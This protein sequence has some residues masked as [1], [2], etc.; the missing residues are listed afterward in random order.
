[1]AD[2]SREWSPS[3]SKSGGGS[4]MSAAL[5]RPIAGVPAWGW[6]F[7][8]SAGFIA[9]MIWR[10]RKQTAAAQA[11][12]ANDPNAPNNSL[13]F[14]PNA[15]DPSTGLLYSQ[16]MP[17]GYGLPAGPLGQF[18]SN[19]PGNPSY[20]V[21]LTEQGLPGPITN[22]QW[23]RLVADSL[24]SKGSDPT[25]VENALSK[26]LSGQPL[27][28]AETA[29][30]NMGLQ[31]FGSPPEGVI[32]ATPAPATAQPFP[33]VYTPKKGDTWESIARLAFPGAT[34]EQQASAANAIAQMNGNGFAGQ[35]VPG[36]A[37]KIGTQQDWV[38]AGFKT[39]GGSNPIVSYIGHELTV[40][41][42]TGQPS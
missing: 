13:T 2:E 34:P 27:T 38:N 26:F 4:G 17:A 11:A 40:P 23:S 9:F 20:P 41:W 3:S 22:L 7:V 33:W 1:M 19:D 39:T 36:Y 15:V 35:P 6:A 12:A 32:P 37:I 30:E 29:V 8:M 16:E 21:G 28:A 25:L 5:K 42:G 18:L 24:I 14:D 10:N 31:L